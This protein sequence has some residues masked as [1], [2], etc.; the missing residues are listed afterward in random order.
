MREWLNSQGLFDSLFDTWL[1][2]G[3]SGLLC[4][5]GLT[6]LFHFAT[7][8]L[9]QM[10]SRMPMRTRAFVL[11]ILRGT[12]PLII[13]TISLLISAYFLDIHPRWH[14]ALEK[15]W[16]II[17]GIQIAVWLNR[18]VLFWTQE[19]RKDQNVGTHNPVSIVF[20]SWGMR[21]FLWGTLVLLVLSNMGIN[22]TAFVTSLGI[23]GVAVA[24]AVQSILSD[25]FAS[26]AI[27]M[28]KPFSIGDFIAFRDIAGTVEYVGL[29][30]TRL[31]GQNG[32]EIICSNTE[33]LQSRIHN[34]KRMEKRPVVFTLSVPY[35]TALEKLREIPTVAKSIVEKA[36]HTTRFERAHFKEFGPNALH[37]E[38]A[39]TIT[40]PSFD[41]YMDI[42]QSINLEWVAEFAK[43]DIPFFQSEY[44]VLVRSKEKTSG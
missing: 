11:E 27:G 14:N 3:V 30:T 9:E 39:Y 34:Y 23:G 20:L 26:L 7:S 33:L 32:E 10:Q 28:D 40:D 44:T 4:Y 13:I 1:Y 6:Y 21:I 37:F 42:Q 2:A 25:L 43:C 22:I 36:H 19:Q 18:G 15:L 29:K 12:Q 17:I 8:R 38:I 35:G 5:L 16:I 41:L 24:L 31:R